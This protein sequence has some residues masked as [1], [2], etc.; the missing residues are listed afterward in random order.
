MLKHL[1]D[2]LIKQER[3]EEKK[4][5]TTAKKGQ[6]AAQPVETE[7]PVEFVFVEGKPSDEDSFLATQGRAA[8]KD[9][10]H[11]MTLAET[12]VT[13]FGLVSSLGSRVWNLES[14]V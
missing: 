1:K 10:Q 8:L 11:L 4:K 12:S 5:R 3:S 14:R 9:I 7:G 6:E 13:R 2:S